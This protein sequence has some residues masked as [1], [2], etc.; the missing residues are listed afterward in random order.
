MRKNLFV[1]MIYLIAAVVAITIV[2]TNLYSKGW[3]QC[4][5][6]SAQCVQDMED[7]CTDD[8][9]DHA[10]WN[11]IFARC[12]DST[13]VTWYDVACEGND[14]IWWTRMVCEDPCG[15]WC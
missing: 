15:S 3:I 8:G 6:Q 13:C 14:R 12:E 11:V 4:R 7:L 10:G 9:K 5:C 2:S 1:I